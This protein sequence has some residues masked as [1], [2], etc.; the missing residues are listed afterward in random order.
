MLELLKDLFKERT[1]IILTILA[2]TWGTFSI[3]TMLAIGEGLR[4][5]F[6]ETMA[7]TGDNL[8]AVTGLRSSVTYRGL[9]SNVVVNLTKS[10]LNNIARLPNVAAVSPQYSISEKIKYGDKNYSETIYAVADNYNT[11]HQIEVLPGG[12]FISP[13]D[14]QQRSKVIVLGSSVAKNIFPDEPNPVGREVKVGT[15]PFLV[16]GVM[17]PKPQII[18][19]QAPD[20]ENNWIPVTTFELFINAQII[21][22]IDVSYRDH[23]LLGQLEQQIQQAVALNHGFDPT[24]SHLLHFRDYSKRTQKINDFFVGMQIFLGIVGALTLL[25]AGVGISNVM[26]ASIQRATRE[27]GIRMAL[28][29]RT[30]NIVTHYVMES[31]LATF[32]GGLLGLGLAGLVVYGLRQI[33]LKGKLIEAIGQPHPTLSLSLILLVIVV[34]GITG[35]LSG[36]FPAFKAARIDPAEALSYE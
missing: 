36:I 13:L 15:D 24:D 26:Y 6:A 20:A 27:I 9:P 33:P 12:R 31:L 19:E 35:L 7:N 18:A 21:N 14:L 17:K 3:A 1:R 22:S 29:A 28:G 30:F 11:I 4:Q 16:I 32:I 8:L 5:T 25:V 34:L 23:E 10:D 2:I